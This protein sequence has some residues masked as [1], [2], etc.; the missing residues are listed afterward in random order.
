[1]RR[2][3]RLA[4]SL[5]VKIEE[6]VSKGYAR[7][8]SSQEVAEGHHRS[9]YLP[10][11]P[12]LN[13][14]KPGKLRIVWD[15]AATAQGVS[16][17]SVLLKGPDQLASLTSVIYKF[18][19]NPIAI[20]GD[21]MEMFHQ[22]KIREEDQNFQRFLWSPNAAQ[23]PDV[24]VMTVMTFG[25][26]CSPC[27][28]QF[29]KNKNADDFVSMFPRAVPSI[30]ENHY[31]DD[32]MDSVATEAEA[33]KLATE[34]RHIHQQ[35]GFHIR[36]W[37]SNSSLVLKAL[38]S[39]PTD[40][41]DLNV[42]VELGTEKVLGMWWCTASDFFTYKL[43]TNPNQAEILFAHRRPTKREVLRILMTIFDP[44]GLL[45]HFLM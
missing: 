5:K 35:G 38:K 37:I 30:R 34:I 8:L 36:N 6:Y 14:N 1:M 40:S 27:S 20:C 4:E 29:V 17:N 41:K 31:V 23:E 21:I 19:E 39:E 32:L 11:F 28:A 13:P 2:E 16:L 18:R 26:T 3:P 15:A 44:L 9:W 42:D 33:I 7:R 43:T 12:V 22:V 25:A 10:I 45:A 24:Y